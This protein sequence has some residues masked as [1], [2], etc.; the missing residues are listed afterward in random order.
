MKSMGRFTLCLRY[1][2]I[3]LVCDLVRINCSWTIARSSGHLIRM[4]ML[5]SAVAEAMWDALG[6]QQ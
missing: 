2:T 3:D 6:V 1:R 5:I 4:D